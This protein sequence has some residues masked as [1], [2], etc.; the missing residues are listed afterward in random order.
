LIIK[1]NYKEEGGQLNFR[2]FI[3]DLHDEIISQIHEMMVK[4]E[5]SQKINQ[6]HKN[7]SNW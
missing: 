2:N 4:F 1:K 3:E 7:S 6:K 5:D